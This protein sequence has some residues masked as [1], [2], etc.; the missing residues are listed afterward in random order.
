MVKDNRHRTRAVAAGGKEIQ[1]NELK[2]V[3]NLVTRIQ[4][5]VHRYSV[6]YMH[7]KTQ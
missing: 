4:D 7:S 2:S 3:F 6:N 5:E 1:I